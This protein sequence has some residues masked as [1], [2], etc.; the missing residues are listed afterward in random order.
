VLAGIPAHLTCRHQSVLNASARLIF[1]P[2]ALRQYLSRAAFQPIEPIPTFS[3]MVVYSF[4]PGAVVQC[5]HRTSDQEVENSTPS[6]SSFMK[7]LRKLFT[8]ACVPLLITKQCAILG[9]LRVSAI[10]KH[11]LAIG[12]TYV[13]PSVC[14]SHASILSKRL[15]IL[16]CFLHH[17]IAHSF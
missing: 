2:E 5:G 7:R 15:N 16:S 4:E 3:L 13:C 1:N 8:R 10:L 11:V 17:T 14:P 12:W 9:V 6:H